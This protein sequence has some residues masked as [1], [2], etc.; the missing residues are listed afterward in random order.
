MEQ[1]PCLAKRKF[2]FGTENMK[3]N[4]P[5]ENLISF[6]WLATIRL[7]Q[8]K[9]NSKHGFGPQTVLTYFASFGDLPES[10]LFFSK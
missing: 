10:H 5:C 8:G 9:D 2:L 6:C 3:M 4:N 1:Q 7:K